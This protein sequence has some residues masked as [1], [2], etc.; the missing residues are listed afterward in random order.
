MK[1]E[2]NISSATDSFH[3]ARAILRQDDKKFKTRT[4]RNQKRRERR[5]RLKTSEDEEA[6]QPESSQRAMLVRVLIFKQDRRKYSER[7]A[8]DRPRKVFSSAFATR[9]TAVKTL[10][11]EANK[12]AS[13]K[14]EKKNKQLMR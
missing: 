9:K 10:A 5:W 2:V 14:V 11:P 1:S 4:N 3:V 6:R 13:L 8:K 7:L 12:A